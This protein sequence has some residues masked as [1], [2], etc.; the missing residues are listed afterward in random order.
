MKHAIRY[1][2]DYLWSLREGL[3]QKEV[4]DQVQAYCM[5]LGYPRSGH[6]LHGALLN[7]H[8]D[9]VVAH[10][11]D[12][13]SYLEG[14]ISRNQ[15]YALLLRR[16]HWFVESKNLQWSD[17]DYHVSNQ[18]QGR[19]RKLKVIGDKKGGASTSRLQ[20]SPHLLS[21]LRDLVQVPIRIIHVVRNPFDN[22][23]TIAR[24]GELSIKEAMERY[25]SLASTNARLLE[26]SSPVESVTLRHEDMVAKP[27][28][29]LARL[30]DFVGLEADQPYLS[31]CARIVFTK[32]SRS[33]NQVQW[34]DGLV[35]VIQ[36]QI[37]RH[38]FLR[39]YTFES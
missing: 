39:G 25:F 8:P 23:A 2:R 28:E 21:K 37:E 36:A 22:I 38:S 29:N 32:P 13:F 34:N 12:A 16:D 7:A 19:F 3:R 6:T 11:L 18:W 14:R 5:F 4:F 15:L 31:D 1:W 24:R 17:F 9:I 30:V 10:E 35:D 26:S 33:R 20:Q 27:E